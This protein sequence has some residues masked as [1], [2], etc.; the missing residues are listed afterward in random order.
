MRRNLVLLAVLT[1]AI[2]SCSLFVP[3][4][5][6]PVSE[7]Q[8]SEDEAPRISLD[9]AR[10]AFDSG[11]AVFVDVRSEAAYA[12]GHI[13]GALSIPLAELE[14]RLDELDPAQW[15]ITYCT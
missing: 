4:A 1:L 14:S 13:P 8:V 11:A 12:E 5:S 6:A 2:L 15:I 9:E 3:T 7:P 10:A